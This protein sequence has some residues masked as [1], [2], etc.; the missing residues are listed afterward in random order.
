MLL[1]DFVIPQSEPRSKSA[2]SGAMSVL[3]Q[4]ALVLM[5]LLGF[6]GGLAGAIVSEVLQESAVDV[7]FEAETYSF[8]RFFPH[9]IYLA[10]GVWFMLAMVCIGAAMSVSQG[11]LEKNVEKSKVAALKTIPAA[12][13]GGFLAGL[14]AQKV[15]EV[16]FDV[17]INEIPRSIGWGVAGG[18]AGLAIGAGFGSLVRLRN[19]GIGGLIGGFVGGLAFNTIGNTVGG[20]IAPR[21]IGITL[22]GTLIG[23][24]IGILDYLTTSA[25]LEVVTAEG[26][27]M[28]YP[29]I[30]KSHVI[31]CASSV[32]VAILRDPGVREQHVR[33]EVTGG[34][35][36]FTC[37]PNMPQVS[38]NGQPTSQGSM[39]NG[40]ILVVGNTSL[41][42]N[43][44]KSLS[45]SGTS[46]PRQP[47]QPQTGTPQQGAPGR[48]TV[49]VNNMPQSPS[50][51]P[52]SQP[53]APTAPAPP[54]QRPTIQMKPPQ[55]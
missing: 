50:N 33:L 12:L 35:V 5:T 13:V 31:G 40:D 7:D 2:V 14:I 55:N 21:L 39:G 25:Y 16:L 44:K 24:A 6:A 26:V 48:P 4:N 17:G 3:T 30:G 36:N 52:S 18:L 53:S 41:R 28:R 43:T 9:N 1:S 10:T 8:G 49:P 11:L 22:I 51:A 34:R 37:L 42:L 54:A 45:F 47:M 29:L 46:A 20:A 23:L 19:G 38:V 15:Y 27:A 32:S